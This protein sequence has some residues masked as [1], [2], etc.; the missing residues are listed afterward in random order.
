MFSLKCETGKL[1]PLNAKV[2]RWLAKYGVGPNYDERLSR[3]SSLCCDEIANTIKKGMKGWLQ[4]T[5]LAIVHHGIEFWWQDCRQRGT[6]NPQSK[7]RSIYLPSSTLSPRPLPWIPPGNA[8]LEASRG[9]PSQLK[10]QDNPGQGCQRPC[11]VS[12]E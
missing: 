2:E 1:K 7:G 9:I 6:S 10:H 3:F 4:L 8:L 11:L 12:R 5:A